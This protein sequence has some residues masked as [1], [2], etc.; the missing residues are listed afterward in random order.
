MNR[1]E[2]GRLEIGGAAADGRGL[3]TPWRGTVWIMAGP[4]GTGYSILMS[5]NISGRA[6]TGMEPDQTLYPEAGR[7]L[8]HTEEVAGRVI[9][10]PTGLALEPEMIRTIDKML[11]AWKNYSRKTGN[12]GMQECSQQPTANR[13][14]ARSGRAENPESRF[15][16]GSRPLA[17]S[18]R[19]DT[20]GNRGSWLSVDRRAFK[21]W[22]DSRRGG[23]RVGPP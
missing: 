3:A 21:D 11:D 12:T 9:V 1:L 6:A 23:G 13:G 8:Q 20:D 17:E 18:G 5:A 10:L 16:H 15:D 7:D 19:M 2:P 14:P 22:L 4:A